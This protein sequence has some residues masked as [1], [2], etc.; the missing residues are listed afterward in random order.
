MTFWPPIRMSPSLTASWPAIMRSVVVLPQPL[1][2][3][4]AAIAR[5]RNAQRHAIHRDSG[6]EAL[7]HR[8]QLDIEA[9]I[10]SRQSF[11]RC[12]SG[13]AALHAQ[14][15]H[16]RHGDDQERHRVVNVPIANSTGEVALEISA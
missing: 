16:Q 10:H 7:G 4:Q 3:E 1:G 14:H 6:A 2:P 9:R 12:A 15:H 13:A 8:D 5:A 11:S